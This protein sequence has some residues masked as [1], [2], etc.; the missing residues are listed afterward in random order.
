[1][2]CPR[3]LFPPEVYWPPHLPV[4]DLS[5]ENFT[6][7]FVDDLGYDPCGKDDSFEWGF[8]KVAIYAVMTNGVRETKHMAR[9]HF[10]GRGW[11]SKLGPDEDIVH[12][13]LKDLEGTLYGSVE[14]IL[15]RPWQIAFWKRL[16]L[17]SS[18]R[19]F[20]YRLRHPSWIFSNLKEKVL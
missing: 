7:A 19:F 4:A 11:L 10:F 16:A 6:N 13:N 12:E 17:Y 14:Q 9:Q 2:D 8:Q 20:I 18:F 5:V 15:K 3:N 1:M